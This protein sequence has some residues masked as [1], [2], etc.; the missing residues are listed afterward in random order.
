MEFDEE[1][2][3]FL[4]NQF[5]G[6]IQNVHQAVILKMNIELEK[7]I[8][9]ENGVD[10]VFG[11]LIGFVERAIYLFFV[12]RHGRMPDEEEDAIITEIFDSNMGRLRDASKF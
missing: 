8:K 11:W 1:D 5:E 9:I 3:K 4:V 6:A 7:K 2:K 10:F 12:S